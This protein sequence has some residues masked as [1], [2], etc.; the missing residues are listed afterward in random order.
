MR[1]VLGLALLALAAATGR[2]GDSA[3]TLNALDK[4]FQGYV[5]L[6]GICG[7]LLI[8]RMFPLIRE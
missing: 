5:K 6:P 4:S 3:G 1:V 2:V 7:G 8:V